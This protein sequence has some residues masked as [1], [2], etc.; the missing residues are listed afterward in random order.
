MQRR[1]LLLLLLFFFFLKNFYCTV[2]TELCRLSPQHGA[3]PN[4]FSVSYP[5]AYGIAAQYGTEPCALL[6]YCEGTMG[7]LPSTSHP[8]SGRAPRCLKRSSD[9]LAVSATP[10]S[11]PRSCRTESPDLR[12]RWQNSPDSERVR[13]ALFSRSPRRTPTDKRGW[14][15]SRSLGGTRR[16]PVR[17]RP[18]CTGCRKAPTCCRG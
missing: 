7:A 5:T 10:T 11:P 18:C 3:G 13:L 1:L 6:G 4:A 14:G 17:P 16:L 12:T 2:C 8:R 15:P 9:L